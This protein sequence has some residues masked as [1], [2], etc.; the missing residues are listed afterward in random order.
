MS[1]YYEL[2]KHPLWQ[3]KR[4][5]I[6]ER[7]GFCCEVCGEE[8]KMLSVHHGYYE[9]GLKPWEYP[10]ESLHCLCE[11]CHREAQDTDLM[12]RKT[13]AKLDQSNMHRVL[14]YALA[15]FCANE[16]DTPIELLSAEVALGIGDYTGLDPS[17]IIEAREEGTID[18]GKILGMQREAWERSRNQ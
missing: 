9:K 6:L 17:A 13:I 16:Y 3:K 10:D 15:A 2:L 7:S 1:T 11:K 18:G 14:G 12:V 4:L 8:E 5:Q